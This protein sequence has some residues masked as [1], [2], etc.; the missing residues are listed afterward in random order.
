MIFSQKQKKSKLQSWSLL[1][2]PYLNLVP[3]FFQL[4]QFGPQP[5]YFFINLVFAITL[6]M[7]KVCVKQNNKNLFFM[8]YHLPTILPPRLLKK[9]KKSGQFS[10]TR[11]I[12]LKS[13]QL[14]SK[15]S[16]STRFRKES[17]K[18]FLVLET[19]NE[20][21]STCSLMIPSKILIN[22]P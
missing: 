11:S 1:F 9:E 22:L 16:S 14:N 20:V 7:K 19:S 5:F 4:C 15:L 21:L 18:S 8:P 2:A 10:I 13:W 17:S 12:Y 6:W 3:N